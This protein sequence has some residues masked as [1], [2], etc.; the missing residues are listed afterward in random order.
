ML[1]LHAAEG[2]CEVAGLTR[3]VETWRA[4]RL[5]AA[6]AKDQQIGAPAASHR[7]AEEPSDVM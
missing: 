4:V 2:E 3:V 6:T 1:G 7:F 5:V